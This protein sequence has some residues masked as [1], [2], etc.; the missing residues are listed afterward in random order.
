MPKEINNNDVKL[1]I[2]QE[3]EGDWEIV[4]NFIW[5]AAKNVIASSEKLSQIA[6][7]TYCVG[8][9]ITNPGMLLNSLDMLGNN[10]LAAALDMAKRIVELGWGQIR[11]ALGQ[12]SGLVQNL[13]S[14]VLRLL[15]ALENLLNSI[16]LESY[17]DFYIW[18][19]DEECEYMFAS[20]AACMLNKFFGAKLQKLEQKISD[21]IIE[22]GT[23]LNDAL[24]EELAD[25]NSMS[26]HI[27]RQTYMMEK[28]TRQ[29]KGLDTL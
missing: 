9:A 24:C 6:N 2:K 13:L 20:I 12:I 5:K 29:L 22:T 25:V 16:R 27:D 17:E 7:M 14:S 28:A 15:K 23:S 10:M 1:A 19:S 18:M 21:K 11:Q 26:A 8:K 4:G 3:E